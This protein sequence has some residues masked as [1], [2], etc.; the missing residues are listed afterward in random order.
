MRRLFALMGGGL[1][2][3]CQSASV[4]NIPVVQVPPPVATQPGAAT[5]M[6]VVAIKG[7]GID[8]RCSGGVGCTFIDVDG[9]QVP[10][11]RAGRTTASDGVPYKTQYHEP[12]SLR[13]HIRVQPGKR[14][15]KLDFY[16]LTPDRAEQ[17]KIIHTVV[18]GR[19]YEL[20][21]Y[22]QRAPRHGGSLLEQAP[23][24][25]LCVDL[26][27]NNKKIRKFCRS[28]NGT[29]GLGEFVEQQP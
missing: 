24:E 22:F 25:P 8:V 19:Q 4:P 26:L 10:L 11:Y 21:Q 17:F 15:F 23:P 13:R 16:P 14:E 28:H 2:V 3:G 1:L 27:E 12:V 20:H 18:A 29:N 9:A 6:E 5:A 7:G